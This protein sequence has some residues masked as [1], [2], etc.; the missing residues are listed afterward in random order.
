MISRKGLAPSAL[1]SSLGSGIFK[2]E[3]GISANRLTPAAT[4]NAPA[5]CTGASKSR[6]ATAKL[7]PIN[8]EIT[9]PSSTNETARAT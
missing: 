7:G 8:A 3:M 4:A 5:N 6:L 2:K 1:A 9:P